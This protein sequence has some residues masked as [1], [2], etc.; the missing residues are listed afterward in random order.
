[1]YY[2]NIFIAKLFFAALKDKICIPARPCN[3]LYINIKC[4]TQDVVIN[5]NT[6]ITAT[7]ADFEYQSQEH[8]ISISSLTNVAPEQLVAIE[9][10][11]SNLRGTKKS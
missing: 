4:G 10:Y 3:I 2:I 11:L 8:I 1:M 6:T 9:G 5:K 7:S